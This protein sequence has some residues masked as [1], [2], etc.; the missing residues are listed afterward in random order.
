MES[1]K[2]EIY[3]CGCNEKVEARLTDGSEI[4]QHRPDLHSLPFWKCDTCGNYVGCHHKTNNPTNPLGNIPT[5]EIRNARREIHKVLDPLWK[6]GRIKRGVLYAKITE[7]VG[8]KY[9]TSKIKSVDE[10]RTVYLAVQ[11]ISKAV[12]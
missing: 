11:E 8:W 2:I 3:C 9:H 4:Y 6:S 5:P 10:A 12:A 7:R 1:G